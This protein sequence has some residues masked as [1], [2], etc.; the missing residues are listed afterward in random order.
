[1]IERDMYSLLN[2]IETYTIQIWEKD[3]GSEDWYPIATG[4]LCSDEV[5]SYLLTCSHIYAVQNGADKV[6]GFVMHNTFTP[7]NE[8]RVLA[9]DTDVHGK[10][11]VAVTKLSLST[12]EYLLDHNYCFLPKE[13]IGVSAPIQNGAKMRVI[14]YPVSKTK[15]PIYGKDGKKMIIKAISEQNQEET[16]F[17]LVFSSNIINLKLSYIAD[18]T[19]YNKNNIDPKSHL[20]LEYHYKKLQ[21]NDGSRVTLPRPE[22]LSGSGL[23][24]FL[25]DGSFYLIGLMIEFNKIRSYMLA[26]RIDY[27]TE[28]MRHVFNSNLP[29]STI[30]PTRWSINNSIPNS[31]K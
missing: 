14:G 13:C 10:C 21:G 6:Q 26:T 31:I 15:G 7:L 2:E 30:I 24:L 27:V 4:I 3:R 8:E 23:W 29:K 11:D 16:I 9:P 19:M 22:G 28:L 20:L 25:E 1:M 5:N 18:I 12:I 17:S